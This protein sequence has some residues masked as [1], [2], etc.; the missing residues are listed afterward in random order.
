MPDGLNF[1]TATGE[2]LLGINPDPLTTLHNRAW[3]ALDLLTLWPGLDR[4]YRWGNDVIPGEPGTV[5]NPVILDQGR[6]TLM[7]GFTGRAAPDGTPAPGGDTWTQLLNNLRAFRSG[8]IMAAQLANT[9]ALDGQLWLPDGAVC[10]ARVQVVG[11]KLGTHVS[12]QT[13][14][15]ALDIV[16]PRGEFPEGPDGS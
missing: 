14:R 2:L 5:E 6:H 16:I 10:E 4:N 1:G 3:C 11:F 8:V 12:A 13:V 7:M 15:A 9:T